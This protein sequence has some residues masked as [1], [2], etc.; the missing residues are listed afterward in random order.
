LIKQGQKQGLI[1]KSVECKVKFTISLITAEKSDDGKNVK[2]TTKGILEFNDDIKREYA[3]FSAFLKSYAPLSK[4]PLI[5]ATVIPPY[6][7]VV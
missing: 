1:P 7:A 3:D 6:L 5:L 2:C 4:T